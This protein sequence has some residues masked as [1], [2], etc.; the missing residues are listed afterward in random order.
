MEV[1]DALK[2]LSGGVGGLKGAR[3]VEGQLGQGRMGW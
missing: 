2:D 3:N 1:S